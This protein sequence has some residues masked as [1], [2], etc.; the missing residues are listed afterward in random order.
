PHRGASTLAMQVA[1]LQR[2]GGAGWYWRLH[3][4][5]AALGLTARLGRIGILRAYFR[6]APYGN[7]ISG[8]ACAARRYFRKPA[9]DISL[10]EAAL[11]AAVP[12]APSRYNLFDA[13]GFAGARRRAALIDRKSTRL[14]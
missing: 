9:Q 12:K 8:A 11:L 7:R 4:A 3:D 2:S 14:N 13:E 5:A 6:D 1:R 10:A